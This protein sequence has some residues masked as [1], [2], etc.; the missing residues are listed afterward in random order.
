MITPI[1]SFDQVESAMQNARLVLN[2]YLRSHINA[3]VNGE[4]RIKLSKK[5]PR[6]YYQEDQGKQY[7]IASIVLKRVEKDYLVL[8]NSQEESTK[9]TDLSANELFMLCSLVESFFQHIKM[10]EKESEKIEEVEFEIIK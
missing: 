7:V 1:I 8:Y 3:T 5:A 9:L 2:A 4:I 10:N 6:F